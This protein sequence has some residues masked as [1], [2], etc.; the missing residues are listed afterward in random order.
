MENLSETYFNHTKVDIKSV[1]HMTS[2]R[3]CNNQLDKFYG[4][5]GILEYKDFVVDYEQNSRDLGKKVVQ[6]AYS[7][8]D[9]S[10]MAIGS[11]WP[12]F[13][14]SAYSP[15][16]IGDLWKEE[17]GACK[18]TFHDDLLSTNVAFF[19]KVISSESCA[20]SNVEAS[21]FISWLSRVYKTWNF[22]EVYVAASI[23]QFKRISNDTMSNLVIRLLSIIEGKDLVQ[24]FTAFLMASTLNL[25]S[26]DLPEFMSSH[27]EK[28]I[29]NS[30]VASKCILD[31]SVMCPM[32]TAVKIITITRDIIPLIVF[33]RADR[34]DSILFTKMRDDHNR[35]LGIIACGSEK[36]KDYVSTKWWTYQ[37]NYT[38]HEI[39][40][41]ESF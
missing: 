14:Q 41:C 38:L 16:Y 27:N 15:S 8:G 29:E 26:D 17:S 11:F 9:L 33:G 23:I 19:A 28:W 22:N 30:S 35:I 2:T 32:I 36:K 7:K 18:I 34:G 21:D 1:M 20:A 25:N 6:H 10:W 39:F 5:F 40:C 31:I 12:G 37:T 13:V 4:V 24:I 3:E